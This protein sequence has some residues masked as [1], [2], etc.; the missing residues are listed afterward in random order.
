MHFLDILGDQFVENKNKLEER[1][2]YFTDNIFSDVAKRDHS[3]E[4]E[5]E[6]NKTVKTQSYF[7]WGNINPYI[8]QM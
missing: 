5:I 8:E 1:M 4:I 2:N 3:D 6:W 7:F